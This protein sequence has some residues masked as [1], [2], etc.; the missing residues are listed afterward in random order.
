LEKEKY[1]PTK[2]KRGTGGSLINVL[3]GRMAS[4]ETVKR[5]GG[6]LRKIG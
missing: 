4:K 3:G 6:L 1:V 2:L 5:K